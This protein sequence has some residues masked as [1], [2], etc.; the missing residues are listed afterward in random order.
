MHIGDNRS[1]FQIHQ[2]TPRA[3]VCN[4]QALR[5]AVMRCHLN[6]AHHASSL[7]CLKTILPAIT[8]AGERCAHLGFFGEHIKIIIGGGNHGQPA[9][10]LFLGDDAFPILIF[11]FQHG[12]GIERKFGF[13]CDERFNLRNLLIFNFEPNSVENRPN[14]AIRRRFRRQA[15]K[16]RF[17]GPALLSWGRCISLQS[18]HWNACRTYWCRAD[19]V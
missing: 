12:W 2:E 14:S 13:S 7:G 1:C 4:N 8:N 10:S 15:G 16:S 11:S 9:A 18:R 3:V 6:A 17:W 5:R 19:R